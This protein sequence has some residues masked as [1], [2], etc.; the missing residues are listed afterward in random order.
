[1][2][3][4]IVWPLS[5]FT[6]HA[7][8]AVTY[9]VAYY[10]QQII[11]TDYY[12]LKDLTLLLSQLENASLMEKQRWVK[13]MARNNYNFA[14][15]SE[16][17]APGLIPD[18]RSETLLFDIRNA[19][20]NNYSISLGAAQ[21][22][23]EAYRL[24]IQL[25]D[26]T[27]LVAI[28]NKLPSTFRWLNVLIFFLQMAAIVLFTWVAVKLATRSLARLATAAETLGTSLH[29]LPIPE[30]GPSE[31][32]RAA[33]AFNAMQEQIKN[34]LAERVHILAS[35]SHDLQTPITRM[36]LRADL[37]ED[38]EQQNKWLSDLNSMQIL[39]EEGITYARSAQRTTETICRVD[40]DALLDSLMCDYLDAGQRVCMSGEVGKILLT[41]PNALKRIMIN[42]IDNALKFAGDAEIIISHPSTE[43]LAISILDRGPGIAEDE[44]SAVLQPFYRLENSRNRKTGGTGLGLA[45]AAQ[46]SQ[47]LFGSLEL[48]NRS[49]GGLAAHLTFP[50]DLT[51]SHEH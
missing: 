15:S 42:L 45:I 3:L 22:A 33:V 35:I 6:G 50:I 34:H 25:K 18:E 41:R 29:G 10:K 27:P 20:G 28:I 51:K 5:L 40:A 13:L 9:E 11:R 32:A 44:L 12:L 14:L 24:G 4:A 31:V 43:K 16:P 19:I 1:M 37:M 49:G 39:V 8:Q 48:K 36:R 7:I 38:T 30:D 21:S 26:G 17:I 2:R 46:L 47:A 23:S